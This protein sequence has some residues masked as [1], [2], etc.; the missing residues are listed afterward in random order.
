MTENEKLKDKITD[1]VERI[2]RSVVC[3][4]KIKGKKLSPN[5][6][7]ILSFVVTTISFVCIKCGFIDVFSCA[8][9]CNTYV[10][11]QNHQEREKVQ[12]E[13][14]EMIK[15]GEI[16]PNTDFAFMVKQIENMF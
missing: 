14:E 6:E 9:L 7:K 16:T 11:D 12:V 4:K 3:L 13:A 10:M 8:S 1:F 15:N 5:E 2:E